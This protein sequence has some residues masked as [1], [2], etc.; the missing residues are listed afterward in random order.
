MKVV[1]IGGERIPYFIA[2]S[3]IAKGYD[4]YIVNK[5]PELCDEFSKT[6]NATIVEGDATTKEVLDQ[7][8]LSQKDIVVLLTERDRKN[9]FIA[10]MVQEYYSVKNIITFLNNSENEELFEKFGIKT[11]KVTDILLKNIESVFI[12][13]KL[14]KFLE[15]E[16]ESYNVNLLNLEVSEDSKIAKKKISELNLKDTVIGGV[17]RD[18]NFIIPRGETVLLP[19]DRVL[20]ICTKE[21]K[22][23]VLE[24]FE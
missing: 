15:P 14:S 8:E 18:K 11:V 21:G 9:F 23:N 24:L 5:D 1:I 6:L 10:R 3:M 16:L 4:V 20:L 19:G 13:A 22:E 17:I 2:K 12:D 7:L